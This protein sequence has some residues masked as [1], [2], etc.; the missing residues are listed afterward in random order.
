MPNDE[1]LY[2]PE[3]TQSVI[4][5]FFEVYNCLGYGFLEHVYAAALEVELATRGHSVG[6]EVLVPVAYKGREI[7][8]HRLDMIVDDVIIV[9]LKAGPTLPPASVRQVFSYLCATHLRLGLVFLFGPKPLVRRAE[10]RGTILSA[11]EERVAGL[12]AGEP[13]GGAR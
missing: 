7:A 11:M 13:H 12:E 5:A 10:R 3:L 4:G 9:E 8:R 2:A 6:R 1:R